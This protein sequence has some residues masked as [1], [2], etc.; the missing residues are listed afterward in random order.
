VAPLSPH[1]GRRAVHRAGAAGGAGLTSRAR[2]IDAI[3]ERLDRLPLALE[4]AGRGQAPL[5]QQ[6][7]TRLEQRSRSSPAGAATSPSANS[8][9]RA[10]IAW[11]YDLLTRPE[12]RLFTR[13]AGVRRQL[14]A[15]GADRSATPI[16]SHSVT[17][18]QEPRAPRRQRPV[19]LLHTTP[20][21]RTRAVRLKRRARTRFAP[22]THAGTF[23]RSGWSLMV[24]AP[25]RAPMT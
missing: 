21:I 19:F 12:Q 15:R 8:T 23:R 6:L 18:R 20:R 13:L 3:C 14:G 10:T 9:M 22:A 2:E 11:S 25:G 5:R 16:L 24:T 17:D 7:L 4:L 1:A